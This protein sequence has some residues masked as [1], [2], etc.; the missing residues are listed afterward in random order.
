MLIWI[1]F[2]LVLGAVLLAFCL[3]DMGSN[4]FISA[5]RIF[6]GLARK[7]IFSIL[8]VGLASLGAR[9]ALLPILPVPEPHINDEFSHLL[10]AD[11]LAHGR[12]SNPPHP[13]W[14]HFESFHINHKPT[15][16]SMYN[17]G[18]AIFMAAGQVIA[19]HPFW[20]VWFSA[21]VMCAAICWA[22][23]GWLP[24]FWAL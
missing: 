12:L 20:G 18:P 7:Q 13:M 11:T 5:E 21:G 1:E 14:I 4:F 2:G 6:S 16:A 23:Q 3:P 24:P 19:G 8:V 22:L 15:Y 10:L 17:P 9:V